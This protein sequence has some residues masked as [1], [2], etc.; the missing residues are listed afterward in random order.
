MIDFFRRHKVLYT[1]VAVLAT[2]LIIALI[3]TSIKNWQRAIEKTNERFQ[4]KRLYYEKK[5]KEYLKKIKGE[6]GEAFE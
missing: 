5:L 2:L 3:A 4:E 1:V 6:A